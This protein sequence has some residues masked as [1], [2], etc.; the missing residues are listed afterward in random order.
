MKSNS[1]TY[2]LINAEKLLSP[3]D[4]ILP[5]GVHLL[6][7]PIYDEI[8]Y[9]VK[10]EYQF[11]S[12]SEQTPN[13][14]VTNWPKIVGLCQ[15]VLEQQSK[16]LQIAAWLLYALVK[17]NG[18]AGLQE[19]L[20]LI[21]ELLL[22]Y[23]EKIHPTS[24]DDPEV[25]L[26]PLIWL[27]NKLPTALNLIELTPYKNQVSLGYEENRSPCNLYQIYL[28]SNIEDTNTEDTP[29]KSQFL[30]TAQSAPSSWHSVRAKEIKQSLKLIRQIKQL[31]THSFHE[32][33]PTY[34]KTLSVL[35][36]LL[37]LQEQA[38]KQSITKNENKINDPKFE[39]LCEQ[40]LKVANKF[41]TNYPQSP[42]GYL[43]QQAVN[44]RAHSLQE[45]VQLLPKL[46]VEQE[47]HVEA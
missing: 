4:P 24:E 19:G 25:R 44:Y 6:Y 32:D 27:E 31:L 22:I 21:H 38:A 46:Q 39:K 3:V 40:L 34:D 42:I 5:C 35:G 37:T 11:H 36:Q 7:E 41:Q 45:V 18:T 20:Q 43:V 13:T 16:D 12:P 2:Q 33:A 28:S 17:T 23:W 29:L 26:S 14:P 10:K 15:E 9:E 47:D 30:K 1:Y 8:I